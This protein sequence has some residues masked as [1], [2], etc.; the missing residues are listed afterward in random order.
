MRTGQLFPLALV[1]LLVIVFL[2]VSE[3]TLSLFLIKIASGLENTYLGVGF[4]FFLTLIGWYTHARLMR[5][6]FSKELKRIGKEKSKI[7]NQ[8]SKI[9]FQSSDK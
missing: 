3:V 2:R 7:Q 1:V 5:K 9:K 6:R 8:N 4:F